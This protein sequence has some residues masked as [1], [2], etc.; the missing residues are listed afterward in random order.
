MITMRC[1]LKI[2]YIVLQLYFLLWLTIAP[3]S[4]FAAPM[5]PPLNQENTKTHI[6]G[7]FIWFELATTNPDQLK[8]FYGQVFNW[9]F[10]TITQTD[11]QYTLIKNSDHNVAGLF[12]AKPREGV[13]LGALWIG[14]MSVDDPGKA[15]ATAKTAGGSVHTSPKA[16]PNRGTY[17]LLRDPEGALFGVLKSDSGDPRD[18]KIENG[19]IFWV[20]LFAKDIQRAGAFYKKLAGY[21][22]SNED[23]SGVKRTFL[24]SANKYRAGI[25]SLPGDANRSGWLPY[26]R[27]KDVMTTLKKVKA[28]GGVVMVEPDKAL[29][30][31]NLAIFS[32]PLG[33]IM[34]IVKWDHPANGKQGNAP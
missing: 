32:D 1:S 12:K 5:V 20:D 27:V 7:K 18:R 19:N 4:V 17:A 23:Y 22:I 13:N 9:K 26:V 25:V 21:E 28:A 34:G 15:A 33:G 31:S 29:L 11:E 2:K 3:H 6:P 30:D 16:L 24:R 10:Q 14:M 8:K